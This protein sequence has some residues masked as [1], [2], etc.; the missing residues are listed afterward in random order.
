L[1][2]QR[3]PATA[4]QLPDFRRAPK[5][6]APAHQ[7]DEDFDFPFAAKG[8]NHALEVKGA[9]GLRYRNRRLRKAF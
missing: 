1:R 9:V 4:Q 3:R 8:M 6:V 5:H 2:L 7:C